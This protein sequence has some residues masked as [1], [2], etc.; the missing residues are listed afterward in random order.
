L[1]LREQRRLGTENFRE[2]EAWHVEGLAKRKIDAAREGSFVAQTG[3]EGRA[4]I[5]A[6]YLDG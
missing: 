1:R 4:P 3:R 5:Q 2:P 6:K